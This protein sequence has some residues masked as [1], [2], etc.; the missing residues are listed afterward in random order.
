LF[1]GCQKNI[2]NKEAI[3]QGVVDHLAKRSDLMA[4]D[5][6]VDG[7]QFKGKEAEALVYLQAKS[8][9]MAAGGGMQMKYTLDRQGAHWVVR[10]KKS[11]A[12]HGG[13]MPMPAPEPEAT[14]A[15]P[16]GHPALPGKQ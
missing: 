14:P 10:E 15:L 5:V 11:D 4:M 3:K 1:L 16:P 13:S 8:G 9:P 12:P 2:E 6:R 7:V